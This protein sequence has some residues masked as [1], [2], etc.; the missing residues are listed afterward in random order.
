MCVAAVLPV[1]EKHKKK[2]LR[3]ICMCVCMCPQRP[4]KN[5]GHPEARRTGSSSIPVRLLD[6]NLSPPEN[7]KSSSD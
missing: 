7:S 3:F 2:K 4:E 5:D 6:L 1:Y